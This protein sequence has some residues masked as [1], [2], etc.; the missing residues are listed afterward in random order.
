[1]A[2][3]EERLSALESDIEALKHRLVGTGKP[4]A[5]LDAVAD[6]MPDAATK[7]LATRQEIT[8]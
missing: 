7:R 1:M 6:S 5:W 2:T 3:V 8:R 4:R